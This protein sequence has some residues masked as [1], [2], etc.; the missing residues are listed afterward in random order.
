MREQ[1]TNKKPTKMRMGPGTHDGP[2]R[3]KAIHDELEV[4]W[5]FVVDQRD[6]NF[7]QN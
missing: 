1:P 5:S 6:W 7:N 4:G 2:D 3:L